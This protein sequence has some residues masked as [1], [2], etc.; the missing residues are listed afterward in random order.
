[1]LKNDYDTLS[2]AINA[3]TKHGYKEGFRADDHRIIATI[4]KKKY[5][6]GEL[7]IIHTYRFDGMTNPQDDTIVFAIEANDGTKGTLVMSYSSK[8]DQNV[9]L[10]KKIP[11][12]TNN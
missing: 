12:A 7:K 10:I 4:S 9:E 3:L 11:M 5:L 6:P 1:M 2:Q 8:H